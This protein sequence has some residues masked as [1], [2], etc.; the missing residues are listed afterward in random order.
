M[1]ARTIQRCASVRRMKKPFGVNSPKGCGLINSE[2]SSLMP[3]Q[4]SSLTVT[5]GMDEH[6][7]A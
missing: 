2:T 5:L 7:V 4:K 6:E 3:C 1:I